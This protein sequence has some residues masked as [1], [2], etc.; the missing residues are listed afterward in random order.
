M[1]IDPT[2]L[3]LLAYVIGALLMGYFAAR[4][5]EPGVGGLC[6]ALTCSLFWPFIVV[7][8]VAMKI[9]KVMESN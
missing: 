3:Y 7:L 2:S 9:D 1:T 4:A 8:L 6:T 5:S